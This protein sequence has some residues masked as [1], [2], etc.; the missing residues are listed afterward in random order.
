MNLSRRSL[1][2]SLS[3][4]CSLLLIGAFWLWMRTDSPGA[5]VPLESEGRKLEMRSV[6]LAP[7]K[8][9]KPTVVD[10]EALPSATTAPDPKPVAIVGG[11]PEVPKVVGVPSP[12]M[13][14]PR[15]ERVRPLKTNSKYPKA[16]VPKASTQTRNGVGRP[17]RPRP[18]EAPSSGSAPPLWTPED[19]G[20]SPGSQ[21]GETGQSTQEDGGDGHGLVVRA[22]PVTF[23]SLGGV[24]E[25]RDL[26]SV[27][28]TA[29]FR[30]GA[31]GSTTVSL[32]RGTGQPALD[33]KILIVLLALK[34]TPKTMGGVPVSDIQ[35]MDI[36]SEG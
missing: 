14:M 4:H 28:V 8:V 22:R 16:A 6:R 18:K 27:S 3:L 32:L 20:K 13:D 11:E 25:F 34:W 19:T 15:P 35:V 29:E 2:I 24:K 26:K 9:E 10:R 23:P 33:S 36:D 7:P 5:S 31:D 12:S 17:S 1:F 30:I 21:P